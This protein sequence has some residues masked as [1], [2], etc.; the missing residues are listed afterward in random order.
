MQHPDAGRACCLGCKNARLQINNS[1]KYELDEYASPAIAK[2]YLQKLEV[3]VVCVA[4]SQQ[5]KMGQI[6]VCELF[7]G[8]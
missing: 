6:S 1:N 5:I 4:T 2:E 3:T 8:F 7:D